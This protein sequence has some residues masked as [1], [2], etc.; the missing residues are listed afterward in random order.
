MF[1]ITLTRRAVALVAARSTRGG[2]PC[3]GPR[4]HESYG[5]MLSIRHVL[6][7]FTS[8][9]TTPAAQNCLVSDLQRTRNLAERLMLDRLTIHWGV[10]ISEGFW[11]FGSSER[12]ALMLMTTYS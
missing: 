4:G 8:L 10:Q 7:R 9:Q 1:T 2:M 3:G 5:R 12:R 11:P 6:H